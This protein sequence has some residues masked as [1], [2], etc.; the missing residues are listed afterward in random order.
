MNGNAPDLKYAYLSNYVAGI[1]ILDVTN[2]ETGMN[3]VGFFD[4]A[5]DLNTAIFEGTWSHYMH[6]SGTVA[7]SSIDRGLFFLTPRMAYD[8]AAPTPNVVPTNNCPTPYPTATPTGPTPAPTG[9]CYD[10]GGLQYS[11]GSPAYCFSVYTFCPDV[12]IVRQFCRAT[13]NSCDEVFTDAPT[14]PTFSDATPPPSGGGGSTPIGCSDSFDPG[15]E[16]SNGEKAMCFEIKKYC[17]LNRVV[18]DRCPVTCGTCSKVS[19]SV[20]LP[21]SPD[22]DPEAASTSEIMVATV[23]VIGSTVVVALAVFAAAVQVK[24]YRLVASIAGKM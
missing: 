11:D 4:V 24:S 12:P 17:K 5:P 22:T 2:V 7:V 15:L 10:E 8:G 13:C 18:R 20:S 21:E 19:D 1:R 14:T 9:E 3:E 23:A 16:F 6:P